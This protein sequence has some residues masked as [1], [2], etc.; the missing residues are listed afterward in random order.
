MTRAVSIACGRSS[1]PTNNSSG[2]RA[3][4]R[5]PTDGAP[6]SYSRNLQIPELQA[7]VGTT[8]GEQRSV[9]VQNA[10]RGLVLGEQG[11]DLGVLAEVVTVFELRHRAVT[12]L[13]LLGFH[14]INWL[15][16]SLQ[17][18]SEGNRNLE[19]P[20]CEDRP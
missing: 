4:H 6:P 17:A 7:A 20:F 18:K 14:L 5:V 16:E 3:G 8:R 15:A 1:R 10:N 9:Q 19:I 13:F 2:R 11:F 12:S